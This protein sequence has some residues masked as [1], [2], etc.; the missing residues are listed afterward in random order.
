MLISIILIICGIFCTI[1]FRFYPIRK[2]FPTLRTLLY[3]QKEKCDSKGITSFQALMTSLASCVGTGNI[4]GVATAMTIGG[5]GSLMWMW[6]AA[7][8]GLSVKFAECVLAVHFREK[9]F[10]GH[11]TG[12]P[13]YVM[14]NGIKGR[15]GKIMGV[16]Y[17]IAAVTA[18]F[19]I[20]NLIQSNAISDSLYS[21]LA[22]PKFISG[23]ILAA[24]VFIVISGGIKSIGRFSEIIV[25]I[26][27][28]I[29]IFG[30]IVV[31]ILNVSII[32]KMIYNI[33]KSTFDFRAAIGGTAGGLLAVREGISKGLFSNES[34]LG[35]AAFSAAAARDTTSVHQGLVSMCGTFIDTFIICTITGLVWMTGDGQSIQGIAQRCFGNI[36]GY[37]ISIC[38]VMFAFTSIPGWEYIGE[39]SIEFIARAPFYCYIY[40]II[41]VLIIF[42]GAIGKSQIVW[43]I[44]EYAN[45]CMALPNIVSIFF[46]S[47]VVLQD[48]KTE[49]D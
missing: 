35:S 46:L 16:L 19:G 10:K 17:S 38:I 49:K 7:F 29:Y 32:P 3:R 47:E 25:P 15:T 30:G 2:L 28:L 14:L 24:V 37:A 11:Y 48:M 21:S 6:I 23:I 20:G 18:S 27:S 31:I 40:R 8:G 9:K 41:F 13:M 42:T 4:I 12:G 1:R 22:I 34:G 43:K 36:G 44:S 26:M 39:K 33:F 45:L 5:C